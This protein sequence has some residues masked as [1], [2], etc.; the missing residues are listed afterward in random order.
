VNNFANSVREE[1]V[2]LGGANMVS[3]RDLGL[4]TKWLDESTMPVLVLIF[5]KRSIENFGSSVSF[6]NREFDSFGSGTL[7]FERTFDNFDFKPSLCN[8]SFHSVASS[9]HI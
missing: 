4:G 7:F 5:L 2:I 3:N 9:P 1:N 8:R 6:F